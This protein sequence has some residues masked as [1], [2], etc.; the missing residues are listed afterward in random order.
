VLVALVLVAAPAFASRPHGSDPGAFTYPAEGATVYAS[1]GSV[2][3]TWKPGSNPPAAWRIQQFSRSLDI[4][5]GC[6]GDVGWARGDAVKAPE[7]S[8]EVEGL[9]ANTCY[10][11]KAWAYAGPGDDPP[12]FTS[13]RIR[14]LIAWTGTEDLYSPGVFSTQQ[15]ITWCI[16]ASVQMMLNIQRGQKDHSHDNQEAYF[17]YARHHDDYKPGDGSRGSD[18]LGWSNALN[19]YGGTTAYHPAAATSYK[20][21][22]RKAVKRLRLTGKPVGLIVMQSNHAWV[23]TG[24]SATADPAVTSDFQVTA[25]YVMGPLYPR[26]AH[27]GYDPAPDTRISYDHFKHFLTPYWDTTIGKAS[28]WWGQFV[29][30]SP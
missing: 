23:M 26:P 29:T 14:V 16:G 13:G 21:A 15:T 18:P 12:L 5:G 8:L 6:A 27:D 9:V 4:N 17:L 25:I 30:V 10:Q 19:Y 24:F 7:P 28:P 20:W 11:W 2:L 3:L 1:P 22:V